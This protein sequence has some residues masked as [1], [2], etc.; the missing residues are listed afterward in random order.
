[1][2]A[3]ARSD[4]TAAQDGGAD[5]DAIGPGLV[6]LVVGPSGAGK[7][8]VLQ[9]ARARL[10]GDRRFVFPRRVV[11]REAGAAEDHAAVTPGE[12]DALL[13]RGAL[14]L[15]WQ[16]HGLRYGIPAEID[17]TVRAGGCVVFNASR[18]AVPLVR[19]RYAMSAAVLIDAPL[20]LRAR[21]LAAR[22]RESADE[23]AA[24]LARVVSDAG[25]LAPDLVIANDGAL[26]HAAESLA[27][28]LQA[29]AAAL[30]GAAPA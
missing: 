10:A 14:A 30:A 6:V 26:E 24:R 25:A 9:A 12:F 18:Y 19:A 23:I 21:R 5:G 17:E 2:P 1:M 16:A 4:G 22:D 27:R 28:W 8:A 20:P 7:D 15:H 13:R 29:R 3:N 11:T